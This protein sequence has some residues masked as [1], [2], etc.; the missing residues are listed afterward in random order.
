MIKRIL[1]FLFVIATVCL[2]KK[3]TQLP[4]VFP[5]VQ[6]LDEAERFQ[7][8]LHALGLVEILCLPAKIK[9]C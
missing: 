7:V 8:H 5:Q 3:I 1:L 6:A 9:V 2:G 4:G